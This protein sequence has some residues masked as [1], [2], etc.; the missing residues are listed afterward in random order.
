MNVLCV[1]RE[2][3]Y[4]PGKVEADRAILEAVAMRLAACRDVRVIDA[5]SAPQR[6]PDAS[7][8]LAMCQ[9]PAALRRLRSWQNSGVRVVNSAQAIENCHRVRMLPALRRAAVAHPAS[10]VV[11]TNAAVATPEWARSGVWVK[12]GDVHATCS[13]DV[14]LVRWPSALSSV[15]AQFR[16]RGI[17]SAVLQQHVDGEVIKFYAVRGAFFAA[18]R[19]GA[20]VALGGGERNALV[21]LVEAAAAALG[22]EIFGGDCVREANG[23]L[24]LIDLNDWPSYAPCRAAAAEAIAQ[25]ANAQSPLS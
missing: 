17:T 15:L 12:R 8:V 6:V 7:L 16:G 10:L 13:D 11:A 21:Q 14:V 23:R 20:A 2:A 24:W 5:E 18:Y 3:V 4:S 1:A 22:V 9:G 25:Y 19:D